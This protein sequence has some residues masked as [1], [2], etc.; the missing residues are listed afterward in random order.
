MCLDQSFINHLFFLRLQFKNFESFFNSEVSKTPR[1]KYCFPLYSFQM[2][3][4][5]FQGRVNL[6]WWHTQGE[7]V[8]HW[9]TKVVFVRHVNV[10]FMNYF[11]FLGGVNV[12]FIPMTRSLIFSHVWNDIPSA[13]SNRSILRSGAP[14]TNRRWLLL[15]FNGTSHLWMHVRLITSVRVALFLER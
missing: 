13:S 4:A 10:L 7:I 9:V 11:I 12:E 2:T 1:P 14:P 8:L 6:P 5:L 3:L 15:A